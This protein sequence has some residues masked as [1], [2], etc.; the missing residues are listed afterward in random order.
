MP[1]GEFVPNG[2]RWFVDMM[3]IPLG[4]MTRGAEVQAPFPV[5]DQLVLPN[6]CYE[7][8]FGEEIA[9]QL[10]SMP[11]PATMLLNVSNL[12]WFGESVAIPQHVQ[13]SQMRSMET[14][15]PMLRST[16][17][18]ATVVIDSQG[19]IASALPNYTQGTLAATVQG[20]GGMTPFIRFGNYT[21]LL[22]AALAMAAA[23]FSGRKYA[24]K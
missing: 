17:S 1:F 22:L 15:R 8:V 18:G 6:V 4:D 24:K 12:A 21:M 3:R 2:F 16:N 11:R 19:K 13:M 20:M 9:L 23:W 7:D 5:K 10:R 14:G